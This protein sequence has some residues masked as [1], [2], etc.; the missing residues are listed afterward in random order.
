[1]ET[2]NRIVAQALTLPVGLRI[3]LIDE[4]Q[5]N[6]DRKHC[7]N[8]LNGSHLGADFSSFECNT[9]DSRDLSNWQP[10]EAKSV[11]NSYMEN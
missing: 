1:M 11:L 2:Y 6:T 8:C 4:I 10:K 9:C 5:S 3:K 7:S